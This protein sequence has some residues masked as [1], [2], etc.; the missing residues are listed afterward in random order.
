MRGP[1]KLLV[2]DNDS[3]P[4]VRRWLM[5]SGLSCRFLSE[6]RYPG[7]CDQSRLDDAARDGCAPS[8]CCTAPT[9]TSSTCP[10]GLTWSAAASRQN[11]Q[12]GQLGLR[13]LGEEGMHPNVGGNCVVRSSVFK[14]VRWGEEPWEPYQK[15]EDYWYTQAVEAAG[16]VWERVPEPCIV[17]HGTGTPLDD[18][19]YLETWTA[20][21]WGGY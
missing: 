1:H 20:K 4:E 3:D 15:T 7:D 19:Y 10:A 18:P 9:T 14:Q 6:N 21:G 11:P 12:L 5:A 2:V 17:H 8:I 13:T 16:Y